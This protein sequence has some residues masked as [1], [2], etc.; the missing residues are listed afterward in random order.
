MP[1]DTA[2]VATLPAQA[3]QEQIIAATATAELEALS[4][5]SDNHG[6]RNWLL[7]VQIAAAMVAVA[8]GGYLLARRFVGRGAA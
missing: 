1:P 4:S 6:N 2:P 3:R 5:D 7:I 8:A